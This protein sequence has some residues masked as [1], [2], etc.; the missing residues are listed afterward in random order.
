MTFPADLQQADISFQRFKW[1]I[2][3]FLFWC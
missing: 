3:T 1:L 2:K